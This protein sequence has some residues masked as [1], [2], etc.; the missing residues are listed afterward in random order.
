M[1]PYAPCRNLNCG[2]LFDFNE[3]D[4]PEEHRPPQSPPEA[5]PNCGGSLIYHCPSCFGA[6]LRIPTTSD[7]LCCHCNKRLPLVQES[8]IPDATEPQVPDPN[9]G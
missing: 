4:D 7:G 3:S 5:C 2:F 6:I 9:V 8:R 1:A